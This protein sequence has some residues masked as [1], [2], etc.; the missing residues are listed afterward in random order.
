MSG[1]RW[2]AV[3][4][5]A[6]VVVFG[7]QLALANQ[8][9]FTSP[10]AG[11]G[12]YSIPDA[13]CS[14]PLDEFGNC[15]GTV[16]PQTVTSDIVINMPGVKVAP[17]DSVLVTL[18]GF[19][20]V[21]AGDITATL[22][23]TPKSGPVSVDLFNRLGVTNASDPS[24]VGD[25]VV[26]GGSQT[27]GGNYAFDPNATNDL[28]GIAG[29]AAP[30]NLGSGDSIPDDI[31]AYQP[32]TALDGTPSPSLNTAFTGMDISGTWS[33]T[34]TNF[35]PDGSGLPAPL[36][37]TGNNFTGWQLSATVASVPEPSYKVLWAL[38]GLAA[39]G[40]WLRKRQ[41]GLRPA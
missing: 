12:T 25:G 20:Y 39:A 29:G 18:L 37:W 16:T 30:Y 6:L 14:V 31:G 1:P 41:N 21:W 38:A 7:L 13:L 35:D 15:S 8:I 11:G 23:F 3:S 5:L 27:T 4:R 32:G 36:G 10:P 19:Q 26:F 9:V 24:D 17:G 40:G 2:G 22:T 34:V 33:L 28:G